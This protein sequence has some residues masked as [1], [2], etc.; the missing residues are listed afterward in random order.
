MSTVIPFTFDATKHLF[1]RDG[2]AVPSVTQ[3]LAKVG[4]CD[5]SFVDEET[6]RYAMERGTSVHWLL[7]LEDEEALD[8]R[9][10]PKAL[11]G[12]RKAY[13]LWKKRSLFYPL[14]IEHK[15]V[16]D[17]GYAGIVDRAG[18]FPATTMRSHGTSAVV[19]FKTGAVPDWVRYQ[20]CAYAVGIE[21]RLPLARYMR[22]IALSLRPDG[23]Y[24]VK[25]FPLC[26]FDS[27]WA[28]FNH[29]IRRANGYHD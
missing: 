25:E 29:A 10:V 7:Q 12:Y 27:D 13:K 17:F 8:Y 15:F 23:D 24:S 26:T 18:T 28:I 9:T 14:L 20:L 16:S 4:I 1:S 3:V 11:R 21:P 6:R 19:D 5:F 2:K 22:R